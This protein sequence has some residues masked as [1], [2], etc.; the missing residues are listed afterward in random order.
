MNTC[1]ERSLV[2]SHFRGEIS[3]PDERRMRAHITDCASC[4]SHY[5]KRQL[6]S[7]IDPEAMIAEARIGSGLGLNETK[8]RRMA[9]PMVV[10]ALALAAVLLLVL[11]PKAPVDDGFRA[12]GPIT[13]STVPTISVMK[14]SDRALLSASGSIRANDELA[15]TYDNPS[16]KP[17]LMIFGV[18]EAGRVYWFYPAWTNESENP[19]AV[20]TD[21][22]RTVATLPEAIKHP[23]GG[24]KLTVHGLFL[25]Q[26]LTVREVEALLHGPTLTAIPQAVDQNF[27][28]EVLR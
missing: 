12:R 6:L 28:F 15:F 5:R 24:A 2:D 16:H 27:T 9:W 10:S 21:P 7:K 13:A 20:K 19:T 1:I 11:R 4:K 18:D 17:Y 23:L 8:P 22:D 26:P 25:D 3:P 14:V